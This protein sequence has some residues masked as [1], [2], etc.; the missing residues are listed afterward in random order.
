MERLLLDLKFDKKKFSR[1]SI[2]QIDQKASI[3]LCLFF[4]RFLGLSDCLANH[5]TESA[6]FL[7]KGH[8][9]ESFDFD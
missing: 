1:F 9:T 6:E 3:N 4:C 5:V 7:P 8:M 2:I